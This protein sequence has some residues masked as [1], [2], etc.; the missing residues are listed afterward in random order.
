[1]ALI[2][3]MGQSEVEGRVPSHLRTSG[4]GP[5]AG[6]G[7]QG[8]DILTPAGPEVLPTM[9]KASRNVSG[10]DMTTGLGQASRLALTATSQGQVVGP[11]LAGP[12]TELAPDSENWKTVQKRKQKTKKKA[13]GAKIEQKKGWGAAK[14]PPPSKL[15]SGKAAETLLQP[16]VVVKKGREAA[17]AMP[18]PELRK[19]K[20]REAVITPPPENLKIKLFM[21]GSGNRGTEGETDVWDII[22]VLP[23]LRCN[24]TVTASGGNRGAATFYARYGIRGG[25]YS[26]PN[27]SWS[28]NRTTGG[29]PVYP[30]TCCGQ[31]G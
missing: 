16:P 30:N 12:A 20:G 5:A 8:G 10:V 26:A 17:Q 2:P 18:P 1:M 11:D 6:H 7:D 3:G 4:Q 22:R 28:N 29:V 19:G 9:G 15:K 24:C 27:K 14:T 31:R 21:P 23:N 25:V 13:P